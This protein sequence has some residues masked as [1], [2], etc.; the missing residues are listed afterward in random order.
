MAALNSI[1]TLILQGFVFVAL[2]TVLVAAHELGH[3]LAARAFG[4]GVDAFAIF[5]GGVRATKLDDLVERPLASKRWVAIGWAAS[6]LAAILGGLEKQQPLFIAGM[7]MSSLV[8]PLWVTGRLE[9]LYHMPRGKGYRTLAISWA[10]AL[11]VLW[12]GAGPRAL[13]PVS[14]LAL[15]LAGSLVALLVLYYHPLSQKPEDTPMG[16]GSIEIEG[17]RKE[18][19]FRPLLCRESRAGTEFSL[20]LLPLG[21]FAA[22]K[23]MVSREDGSETRIP[24]GFYSKPPFARFVVLAAGPFFSVLFGSLCL[25]GLWS[26]VGQEKFADKPVIG[27]V[28]PGTPAARA[29][30]KAGDIVTSVD[31][32]PIKIWFDFVSNVRDKAGKDVRVS[33]LREGKPMEIVARPVPTA[34]PEPVADAKGNPSNVPF[35]VQG[36]LGV[37][38][39]TVT[40][41]VPVMKAARDAAAAPIYFA[42]G[43]VTVLSQPGGAKE[44]LGGPA[45]IAD[46]TAKATQQG[47][48]RVIYLAA[49]LSLSLAVMNLLP[50]PPF[51]GGQMLMAVVEM[52]RGGRR[53]SIGVQ[54]AVSTVGMFL[55]LAL[56]LS[57]TALDVGRFAGGQNRPPASGSG[58]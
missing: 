29:G 41:R 12:F 31:G 9:A 50:I 2:L 47:L 43:L 34:K 28:A 5:M 13:S 26:V 42:K 18:V 45:A 4:M 8:M 11:G 15:L 54:R 49:M 51:D 48:S 40:E 21:G 55:V 36:R 25:F 37:M 30:M 10:A 33:F 32:A 27:E 46:L 16:Y 53:L 56:M 39:S 17:G 23:G 14:A 1:S 7:A 35:R 3:F 58:K 6:L 57:I 52:L 44:N 22:I 19:R 38:A 24:G 20:L